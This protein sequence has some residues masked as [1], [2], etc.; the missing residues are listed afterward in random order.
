MPPTEF[1]PALVEALNWS[2]WGAY[3][4]SQGKEGEAIDYQPARDLIEQYVYWRHATTA[5][6]RTERWTK[7]LEIHADETFSIGIVSMARQ[8]VVVSN[9]MRN[10]PEEGIYGW[11]PGAQYGIHRM[12]AFWIDDGPKKTAGRD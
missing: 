5:E 6:A 10:V 4:E 12:D 11:D 8:P 9:K 3:H 2:A 1:A 7:I